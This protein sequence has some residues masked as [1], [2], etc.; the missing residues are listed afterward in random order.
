MYTDITGRDKIVRGSTLASNINKTI[1]PDTI[2]KR[3]SRGNDGMYNINFPDRLEV[4]YLRRP[5]FS[6]AYTDVGYAVSWM[7]VKEGT[8]V[9][10][11]RSGIIPKP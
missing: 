2:S 11:S 9:V 8:T 5:T 3:V 1:V 4:H 7:E 10:V 6:F